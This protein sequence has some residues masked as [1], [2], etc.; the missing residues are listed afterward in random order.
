[1]KSI[2]N[3]LLI[4]SVILLGYS[5]INAQL[6]DVTY[7]VRVGNVF[8]SE[9]G[10]FGPCWESGNEEYTAYGG[11]FDNANTNVDLSGCLQC[12]NNGNCNYGGGTFIGS[13]SNNAYQLYYYIDAWEDDNGSRC[14]YNSGD[15]C[16]NAGSPG[17]LY[18]REITG[19]TNDVYYAGGPQ[20]GGSSHQIRLDW[21]WKYSGNANALNPGC[22]AAYASYSGGAIHSWSA[23]L[24]AG[25]TYQFSTLGLSGEDTYIRIYSP[26]G[27]TLYASNDDASGTLQ[28]NA[29]FTPSVSGTYYVEVSRF[30]RQYLTGGGSLMYQDAS[31][32]P[33]NGGLIGASST[34]CSGGGA[35]F[36][37]ISEA[38]GGFDGSMNYQWQS[39][40][41]GTSWSNILGATGSTY[42]VSN[43]TSTTYFRRMAADCKNT[44]GYSN[45]VTVTV[46]ADPSVTITTSSPNGA[47][48]VGGT[49]ALSANISGGTGS[50]T[51]QWQ[52]QDNSGNWLNTG[53]GTTSMNASP[54]QSRDYRILVS[55][56]LGCDAVAVQTVTVVADPVFTISGTDVTCNGLNN[57]TATAVLTG[58]LPLNYGYNWSSNDGISTN[59]NP[60]GDGTTS[61]TGLFPAEWVINTTASPSW[62]CYA[63]ASI[64][65]TEPSVLTASSASGSIACNGGTTT[66]TVSGNGGTAPYSGT[67][68]FT[69]GAGTYNYTVTD[70]NGCT[71]TTSITVT[72][73]SALTASISSNAPNATVCSGGTAALSSSVSGGTGSYTLQWQYQDNSGNWLNTGSGATVLNASPSQ[74]R[75]YRL[76]VTDANGCSVI[77]LQT[78][79]V[80]ADPVFTISGTN[81]T[82]NG[83]NNGT[84]TAVLTGGLP[85]NYG[86][87]W[88]SNDGIST[89]NN[90]T[91][92]GTTSVTGLFPAEW[93]INTTASPSWGCYATA[94]IVIT[95]PSVL[96]ASSASGSIACNGGTTTVTVSG[97]GGT[98]PYSGTG[99]F[100]VGA[101][102]YNYTVTD[103]NGCTATTSITVTEPSALT[104]SISSNAPNATVCSGGTAAL[105]SSVSGGTGSYTLQWQYQDNSGNWLNTGSGATVLNASPSQTRDYRL[106]VTDAN[107]CSVIVVQTVTVI[108][109]PV[110]TISGTNVTCNGFNDG[111]ATAVLTGGLPLNYGYNWYS[112]D[113]ISSNNNPAGDGTTSVTGLFPTE[114]VINTTVAGPSFGCYAGASITITEPTPLSSNAVISDAID[115]YGENGEIIVFAAGGTPDYSG[116]GTFSVSAGD[117]SYTVTDANGCV[118]SVDISISQPELLV[119]SSSISDDINCYGET[120][121]ISVSAIGGTLDYSGTGDFTVSAGD[122]SYTVTDANGCSST[123]SITIT[124]PSL[125]TINA[126]GDETVFY[127]YGPMSCASLTAVAEG[128]TPDYT[129]VWNSGV[130]ADITVCPTENGEYTVS[131]SDANGCVATDELWICVVDVTC[132]A[133][134][135]GNIKVEMCQIPPGN[136]GNAHTICI[137]ASAVPAHLAIGCVLGACGELES[138]CS[139]V[140]E[141]VQ[142]SNAA[143]NAGM[144]KVLALTAYPNPVAGMT[145]IS[146]TPA[147]KG[148]YEIRMID[149][150]GRTVA[151]IYNGFISDFEN[152]TFDMD[153]TGMSAGVYSVNVVGDNGIADN[154]KIVKQ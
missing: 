127:G 37:S 112:N 33:V 12:N 142:A 132:Q 58:G 20:A 97:N 147:D 47:I 140:V 95:E 145:T 143:K 87:N 131:V 73:P 123:T 40:S 114:W 31:T 101:G 120:G 115:C 49:T 93:V 28:S 5:S 86:Y 126:G 103:A 43:L 11:F 26:D 19:P 64:V 76:I 106:I 137:D 89:N 77:V 124:E 23:N 65:I 42:A 122:Y 119:A 72:E 128:G 152:I 148:N 46:N 99:T 118:S 51:L 104:A 62:G 109:D 135:S 45:T 92:D 121:V 70:A 63:T 116:I 90:P 91:G 30:D 75:D 82:C 13:R 25:R 154:I 130:G 136:P 133:G 84:A 1:M 149:M 102:T 68:T 36:S 52:Y 81:V 74:T 24:N 48:C 141:V 117:Y 78:V 100:T 144:S 54:T 125:L 151:T 85:L 3:K 134:N 39:S 15:D 22:S 66:V 14:S 105:S 44:A 139:G 94:S 35:S 56:N 53:S 32:P 61:V 107:G 150:T 21:T 7:S 50:Y 96:T 60:T 111:T 34:V 41:N 16:R 55:N 10:V 6:A 67:G 18:F 4:L 27:F 153:M 29:V 79:T 17:F 8:S 80:V 2:V 98:A 59:N 88:S 146:V 38:S 110:F 108:A 57:G 129:Y 83:L 113:G 138:A 69:V 71:A 9:G